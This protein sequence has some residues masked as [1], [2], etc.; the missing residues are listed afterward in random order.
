MKFWE[1]KY[2]II[3][4]HVLNVQNNILQQLDHHDYD[5]QKASSPQGRYVNCQCS[6][7][8]LACHWAILPPEVWMKFVIECIEYGPGNTQWQSAEAQSFCDLS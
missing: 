4:H 3:V 5:A 2:L 6:G 1:N 8:T 7:G